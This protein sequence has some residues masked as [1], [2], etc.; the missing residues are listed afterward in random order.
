MILF[1][2]AA[3]RAHFHQDVFYLEQINELVTESD[4]WLF[5]S[6]D[7]QSP[8]G[9]V[10]NVCVVSVIVDLQVHVVDA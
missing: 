2:P 1:C 4:S 3:L 5:L 10:E 6:E 8:W 7:R 9:V